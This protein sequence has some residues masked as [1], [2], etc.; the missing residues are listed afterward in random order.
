MPIFEYQCADCGNHFE[1]LVRSSTVLK[2]LKCEPEARQA[3]VGLRHATPR[4][5]QYRWVAAVAGIPTA[6]AARSTDRPGD[7]FL[8]T[9]T[10]LTTMDRLRVDKW[11]WAARFFKTD[12]LRQAIDQGH[13]RVDGVSNQQARDIAVGARL[14]VK[15]QVRLVHGGG[16]GPCPDR[17]GNAATAQR[18]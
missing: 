14:E 11:L 12:A 18:F 10:P 7:A 1:L 2:C 6:R 4:P 17:R 5:A 3:V 8:A 13:V 15:K 9:D 16:Q